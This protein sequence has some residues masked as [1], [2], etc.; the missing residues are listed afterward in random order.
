M[1]PESLFYRIAL[2]AVTLLSAGLYLYAARRAGLSAL[3][4]AAGYLLG[5][6]LAFVCAKG[7]YVLLFGAGLNE[8][9]F[10]KW[11]RL[12]PEEFS[13]MAGAAGFCLGN[14]LPWAGRRKALRAAADRL[15]FPGCLLAAAVRFGEIFSGLLGTADLY[16]LG[17]GDLRDGALFAR[18]PFAVRDAWGDWY[19]AVSTLSAALILAVGVRALRQER[20]KAFSSGGQVFEQGAFLFCVIPFFL[21]LVRVKSLVFYFVHVDQALCAVAM[22]ALLLRA[23]FRRRA[24]GGRFPVLFPVLLAGCFAVNGV[25]QYLMDKPWTVERLLRGRVFEWFMT[26]LVPVSFTALLL[27]TI[28]PAVLMLLLYRRRA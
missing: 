1:S 22:L 10:R 14:L 8:T 4:A 16:S 26:N 3:R 12:V 21:E 28:A 13:F 19:P 15:V 17:L 18:F 23:C 7:L 6:L 5:L 2:P 11:T 27:T 25:T 24:G 9:G 20:K